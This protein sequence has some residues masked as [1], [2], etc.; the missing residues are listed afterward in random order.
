MQA[1]K[2]VV[3]VLHQGVLLDAVALSTSVKERRKEI[4][5]VLAIRQ[6]RH[7]EVGIA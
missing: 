7:V 6:P 3:S 5:E 1:A 4:K 2:K